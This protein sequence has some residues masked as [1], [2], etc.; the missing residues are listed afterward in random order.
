MTGIELIKE[1]EELRDIK[2]YSQSELMNIGYKTAILDVLELVNEYLDLDNVVEQSLL[3][4][5]FLI[6]LE[7]EGYNCDFEWDDTT[8]EDYIKSKGCNEA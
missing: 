2:N 3:L 7:R 1:L 5:D 6:W 4:K 8:I